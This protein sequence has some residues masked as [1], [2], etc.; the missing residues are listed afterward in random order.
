MT[1]LT[2]DE[3]KVMGF[4]E[5]SGPFTFDQLLK[6]ATPILDNIT[7][8]FYQKNDISSDY[9][10]RVDKFKHALGSQIEYFAETH[11]LT[12]E[13][14][15]SYPQS[16]HIGDTTITMAGGKGNGDNLIKSIVCPDVYLHL[17]WTGLLHRGN[18]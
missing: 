10:H 17:E 7:R 8:G 15:N 5:I 1:Y 16:Q 12:S 18:C 14:L 13:S 4:A 3:Y 11:S 9:P 2:D 6:R